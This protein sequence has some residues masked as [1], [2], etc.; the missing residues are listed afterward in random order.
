MFVAIP[1]VYSFCEPWFHKTDKYSLLSIE[2]GS[3]VSVCKWN[4]LENY[5]L[6]SFRRKVYVPFPS[7]LH[8]DE[9]INKKLR[10]IFLFVNYLPFKLSLKRL[11]GVP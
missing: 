2:T 5:P 4:I 7:L 9:I 1:F 3:A 11:C 8:R 6:L 10:L